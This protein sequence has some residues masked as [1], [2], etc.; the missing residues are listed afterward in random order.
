MFDFVDITKSTVDCP[1]AARNAVEGL[2]ERDGGCWVDGVNPVEIVTVP[3]KPFMLIM[4]M[5]EFAVSPFAMVISGRLLASE[6][7]GDGAWVYVAA[8][9]TSA[10]PMSPPFANSTH[11]D[12]PFTLDGL[13]PV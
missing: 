6:M 8:W 9:T 2:I 13:Q 3:V 4:V 5:V 11:V 1:S 12:V 10:G 7:V